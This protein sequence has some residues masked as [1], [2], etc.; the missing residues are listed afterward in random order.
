[1]A[2]VK[3]EWSQATFVESFNIYRSLSTMNTASMPAPLATGITDHY[4]FD[5]SITVDET[6]FYRVGA[7]RGEQELIS[8][9]VEVLAGAPVVNDPVWPNV[10]LLIFADAASFPSTAIIDSSSRGRAVAKAGTPTI[11]SPSVITPK[12]D[13]GSIYLEGANA[14][15]DSFGISTGNPIG[16]SDFTLEAWVNIPV[17]V[18]NSPWY[19]RLFDMN[20]IMLCNSADNYNSFDIMIYSNSG[21][22]AFSTGIVRGQ[23]AHVCLMR[24]SGLVMCFI[25]GVKKAQ[26]SAAINLVDWLRVGGGGIAD[27]SFNVYINSFRVTKSARYSE[28]GFTVPDS[29]FPTS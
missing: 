23:W 3:L 26:V 29:K 15:E 20:Q 17:T 5:T 8:S 13:T 16:T 19:S 6:Y 22:G 21:S 9:E 27:R 25:N 7:V 2:N 4:Y 18:S 11:V 1:M 28:T 12:F 10:E 14:P 24:K